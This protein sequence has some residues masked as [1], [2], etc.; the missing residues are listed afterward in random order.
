MNRPI[1]KV[2]IACIVMIV[3]LLAN[4]TYVQV[5]KADKLRTDTRN[6][7][8]LLD[9]YARQRGVIVAADGTVLAES[10]PTDN[11]F[12][13]L[14][15]Y[16]NDPTT[17]APVTGYFSF[18]YRADRGI[19][20]AEDSILNGNDDRLFTQRFMDMFSGRDPRG[21]NV[22]TTID[23][24]LQRVAYRELTDAG[25]EGPCRGAVVALEPSTGKILA[26][27]STPSYDPNAL[28]TQ[29]FSKAEKA[30][31]KF[32]A[33][34]N[35]DPL[36]NRAI[37]ALY[38]PGSTFKVVTTATALKA[39]VSP[40]AR[41]TSSSVITLPDSTATLSNDSGSTCP[42]ASN[43]TVTLTQAFEYSCNT[44]FAQL[45]T[46]KVPG[47]ASEEFT[48]T[49]KQF[50]VG[51]DPPGIPMDVA[52]STVG[53]IGDDRAALAQSAIGQRDVRL[54]VLENAEIAATVANGGVRM[55]PYLVDKLQTADLRTISTT[56][57]SAFN[58]PLTAEEADQI[59]DMMVK[60]EQHTS[61]AQAGIASKTGTAEHSDT[62]GGG[63]TPYAW[64]IAF[65]PSSNA[66][67]AVAVIIENGNRGQNSYGGLAAAPIG[68]AVI[69]AYAGGAR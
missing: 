43:G 64:Y 49:A 7:R 68:R 6:S 50:G 36:T 59:T 62:A 29:D 31:E 41:L 3:A 27:A 48:A 39:G 60:S 11:R 46:E 30:W 34:G 51:E 23:P 65:S 9:E 15:Q 8:V 32:N 21:G 45:M 53:D 16:P 26:L 18:V 56:A 2:A 38:P 25:C 37:N 54:T 22:V 1:Q 42:G 4:V 33:E 17:F 28:A 35:D 44:A 12:K 10:V 61:G 24:K 55:R 47:D 5:F 40:D 66:R 57:P 52:K 13:Y 69:N 20:Y 19:E 63:E 58:R 67:I 14:R